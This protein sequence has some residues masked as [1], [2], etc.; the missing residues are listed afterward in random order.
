MSMHEVI[1]VPTTYV[2]VSSA[3]LSSISMLNTLTWRGQGLL[4]AASGHA[5]A[6]PSASPPAYLKVEVVVNPLSK[7]AQ[8]LSPILEWLHSSFQ[9]SIKV[10]SRDESTNIKHS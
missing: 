4:P 6:G 10:E 1:T 3:E 7:A 8:R 5:G 9:A 2:K